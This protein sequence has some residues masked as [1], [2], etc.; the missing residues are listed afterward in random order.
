MNYKKRTDLIEKRKMEALLVSCGYPASY[1]DQLQRYG[2]GFYE[3]Q[4]RLWLAPGSIGSLEYTFG[5]RKNPLRRADKVVVGLT[6]LGG[7]ALI[8]YGLKK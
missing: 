4:D 1:A 8:Y 2:V 7:L 5:Y 6:A 3:L